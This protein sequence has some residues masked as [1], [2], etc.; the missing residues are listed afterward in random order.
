M[1]ISAPAIS[2][3]ERPRGAIWVTS[4]RRR[5]LLDARLKRL[6]EKKLLPPKM[7][8]AEAAD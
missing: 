7:I 2:L 1:D 4:V 3:A 8:E 6:A 5:A